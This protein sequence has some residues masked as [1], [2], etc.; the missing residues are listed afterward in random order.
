MSLLI[1][2]A[3][4]GADYLQIV[5]PLLPGPLGLPASC[6]EG[7][8]KPWPEGYEAQSLSDRRSPY[9]TGLTSSQTK[10]LENLKREDAIRCRFHA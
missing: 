8:R 4:S 6:P 7:H 5:W 2:E 9:R 3:G 10:V 1:R